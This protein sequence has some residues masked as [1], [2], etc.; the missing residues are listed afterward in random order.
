MRNFIHV[1]F[2]VK[3]PPFTGKDGPLPALPPS[4]ARCSRAH[5]PGH[6]RLALKCPCSCNVERLRPGLVVRLADFRLAAQ[7]RFSV[8]YRVPVPPTPA[9]LRLSSLPT[10]SVFACIWFCYALLSITSGLPHV[11]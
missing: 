3:S 11:K 10:L 2:H 1:S 7:E 5:S 6:S 4:L 9:S 8:S